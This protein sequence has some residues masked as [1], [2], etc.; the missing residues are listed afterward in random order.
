MDMMGRCPKCGRPPKRNNEQNRLYWALLGELSEKVKPQGQQ[1]SPESWHLY[2][3]TTYLGCDDWIMPNG[4]IVSQ[5]RSTAD[6]DKDEFSE[7]L[8]QVIAWAAERGVYHGE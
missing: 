1:Y 7:Y 8:E 3:K 2:F 5:P 4:K 6:L